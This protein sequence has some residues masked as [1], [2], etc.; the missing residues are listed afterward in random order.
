[1]VP[2]HDMA[3]TTILYLV[4][5]QIRARA[6][7][8]ELDRSTTNEGTYET[9]SSSLRCH[10]L[11]RQFASHRRLLYSALPLPSG[12]FAKSLMCYPFFFSWQCIQQTARASATSAGIGTLIDIQINQICMDIFFTFFDW[13]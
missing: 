10:L 2:S 11:F 4:A 1:M 12:K 5:R 7:T 9:R 8:H 13:K 6:Y 3:S